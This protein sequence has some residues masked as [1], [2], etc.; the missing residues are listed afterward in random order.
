MKMENLQIAGLLNSQKKSFQR[1][2]FDIEERCRT[3]SLGLGGKEILR[4]VL[5]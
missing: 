4:D 3:V 5:K 1:G 2:H